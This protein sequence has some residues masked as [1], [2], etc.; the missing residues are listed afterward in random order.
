MDRSTILKLVSTCLLLVLLDRIEFAYY[1][2]QGS[3]KTMGFLIHP[4]KESLSWWVYLLSIQVQYFLWTL[5]L[6]IWIPF[7]QHWKWVVIAFALCVIEYPIT[8]GKPIAHLPLPW[9]WFFPLSASLLRLV[10]IFY[11]LGC[12]VKKAIE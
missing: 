5:I 9:D 10:A 2:F 11:Y 3:G 7:K 1:P 12:V 6:W 8:F 4:E